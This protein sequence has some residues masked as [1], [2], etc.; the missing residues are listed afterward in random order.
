MS[1]RNRNRSDRPTASTV[2]SSAISSAA[3]VLLVNIQYS[4][5]DKETRTVAVTSAAPNE[6]K[7]V[8]SLSLAIAAG[9]SG[10]RCLIVESDMRRRSLHN[11]IKSSSRHGVHSVLSGR[12]TLREAVAKTEYRG[13][14]FLDAEPGI[15]NPTE[16]LESNRY[17]SLVKESSQLFDFVIFDCPPLGAYPDAA[18]LSQFVDGTVMVIRSGSTNRKEAAMAVDQLRSTGAKLLG[19]VL[20]FKKSEGSG[21]YGYYGYYYEDEPEF[22]VAALDRSDVV[23]TGFVS[24]TAGQHGIRSDVTGRHGR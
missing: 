9:E 13:V 12:V 19:V 24:A 22:S 5:L 20:T 17:R 18:V 23:S 8:V 16:L 7:T 4:G 21:G 10:K 3:R 15:P 2:T 1:F 11:V 14:Y 6:G